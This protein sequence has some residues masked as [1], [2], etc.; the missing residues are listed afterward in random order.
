VE[1]AAALALQPALLLLDEPTSQLDPGGAE[2]FAAALD[3]LQSEARCAILIAEHRTERF[4]PR[5]DAVLHIEGGH[6][7][8]LPPGV[9]AATL[10]EAP[11][12]ALLARRL[13]IEPVPL[14]L[15]EAP[16]LPGYAI[17]PREEGR[18]PGDALLSVRGLYV[19]Y[20][21]L[22]ALRGVDLEVAEGE[23][24]ALAGPN[25]SGKTSL[26][27]AIAGTV[28]P[29]AG[30]ML[31]RRG[32]MPRDIAGRTALTGYLPQ[33][34]ALAFY[35][36]SLEQEVA[37]S[38]ANRRV[39]ANALDVLGRWRLAGVAHR[40]PRDLSAGQQER[41][42]LATMLA[43]QPP[44]WLLDEPTR[45]ADVAAHRQLACTLREHAARGGA[46]VVATHDVES[47]AQWAT[48]VVGLDGGRVAFDLPARKALGHDG[49]LPTQVARLVPGAL[50]PGEVVPC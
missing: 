49:P 41:A 26:F 28:A 18:A 32:A 47:A 22:E 40:N 43:H 11:R 9:A 5:A 2:A 30:S 48:R 24:V 50:T 34:P 36:D 17:T 46:A 29:V 20:G 7:S 31:W 42:A 45:G 10:A 16:V 21:D 44:L 33:D 3:A 4:Y 13:G 35:R 1:L 23:I 8:T 12:V 6:L 27:R 38:L 25:G 14:T 37:V 39:P 15:G 19:R